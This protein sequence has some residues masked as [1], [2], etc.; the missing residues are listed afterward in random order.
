MVRE[1]K[2]DGQKLTLLVEKDHQKNRET[3]NIYISYSW[4]GLDFFY[5][6]YFG[7]TAIVNPQSVKA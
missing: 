5:F 1:L 2:Q 7:H 6:I 4:S 3:L